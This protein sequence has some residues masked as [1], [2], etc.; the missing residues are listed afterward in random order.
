MFP[1]SMVQRENTDIGE[2]GEALCLTAKDKKAMES[3]PITC[4]IPENT[5]DSHTHENKNVSND[6]VPVIPPTVS[7]SCI[8]EYELL[9]DWQCKVPVLTSFYHGERQE[10]LKGKLKGMKVTGTLQ[11]DECVLNGRNR[12]PF[13]FL[14]TMVTWHI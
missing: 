3:H 8:T 1:L 13:Q 10:N 11:C 6:S 7:N 14:S 4:V 12:F 2:W 9:K 5:I